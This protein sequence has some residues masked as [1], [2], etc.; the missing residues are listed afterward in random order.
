VKEGDK[1]EGLLVFASKRKRVEAAEGGDLPVTEKGEKA[2]K[3]LLKIK[4]F[5]E[6]LEQPQD[7][8]REVL[9]MA[10][11]FFYARIRCGDARMTA[12]K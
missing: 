7:L 5:F 9:R 1:S 10:P 12:T 4:K 6:M 2:D 8:D 3:Y 11:I